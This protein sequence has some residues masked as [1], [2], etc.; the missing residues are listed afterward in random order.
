MVSEASFA[1]LAVGFSAV[2]DSISASFSQADFGRLLPDCCPGTELEIGPVTA[3]K[4][5]LARLSGGDDAVLVGE[6]HGLD[7]VAE[8]QLHQDAA[9]VA[10]DGGLGH[11]ESLRDLAV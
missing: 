3:L 8:I 9:D 6:D 11:D 7:A 10:L 2:R 1:A 5:R 4:T